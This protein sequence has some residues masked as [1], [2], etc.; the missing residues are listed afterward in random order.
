MAS[1]L[2]RIKQMYESQSRKVTAL[3]ANGNDLSSHR[4]VTQDKPL[5]VWQVDE[6]KFFSEN[7]QK[8]EEVLPDAT[9]PAAGLKDGGERENSSYYISAQNNRRNPDM[10][11]PGGAIKGNMY[12]KK[13]PDAVVTETEPAPAQETEDEEAA[14]ELSKIQKTIV[15]YYKEENVT[16]KCHNCHGFGHMARECPN[17]RHKLNCILCGK[18]SHESFACDAKLCFKCNKRGHKA[19]ECTQTNVAKCMLCGQVGHM[20]LRC[21]KVWSVSNQ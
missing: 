11:I 1:K 8:K 3:P 16:I 13:N 20:Q 5:M 15:R 7:R 18:D 6:T 21:L 4:H 19:S 2:D 10:I 9:K 12:F 14:D 17:E